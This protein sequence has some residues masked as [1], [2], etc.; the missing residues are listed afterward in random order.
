MLHDIPPPGSKEN[1]G[2]L[3]HRGGYRALQSDLNDNE[4]L[5]DSNETHPSGEF[6]EE[7]REEQREE[8]ELVR[9]DG[10]AALGQS[11]A[12]SASLTVRVVSFYSSSYQF[13][14]WSAAGLF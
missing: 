3:R 10:W 4:Q 1:D 13:K 7:E 11:F 12:T 2:A 5:H 8:R 6:S 14:R 9:K